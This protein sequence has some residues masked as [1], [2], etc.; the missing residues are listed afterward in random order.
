MPQRI[1]VIAL[2]ALVLLLAGC[3]PLTPARPPNAPVPP[4]AYF[5]ANPPTP[6]PTNTPRPSPTP[7]ATP[8]PVALDGP[9][10]LYITVGVPA[11][12][13]D[14]ILTALA[15]VETVEAVNGPQPLRLNED[16]AGATTLL[17]VT[18]LKDAQAPLL[19]RVYAVVAPFETV[20][21]EAD[22]TEIQFRWRGLSDAPLLVADEIPPLLTALLGEAKVTVVDRTALVEALE[23]TPDALALVPFDE[24]DP[25]M[26]VLSING[27]NVLDNRFDAAGYP[28]A[29]ALTTQG[30]G[31]ALLAQL[32]QP[33]VQQ[34]DPAY[35]NRDP[36][37]LSS[38]IMTGVTAMSRGTAARMER[39]GYTYPAAVISDTLAAA[40][41]TH[42]SNE[43][44]FLDDCQVN[45]TVDNL[46][47]CSHDDYWAALEAVG[48]D[49]VGLSGNH[50]NDFGR[51]GA[52]RS[53]TFYR[54]NE[55]P[56]YGS[57]FNVEEACQPLYWEHNGNRFA[58][59]A[60]LAFG[61]STAWATDEEPGACHFYDHKDDIL[62]LV[63]E[64][65]GDVDVVSVELQYLETYNPFPTP[66]QVLEFRELRAAGADIVTGVQSHVPQSLE[67]YGQTDDGGPGM[68]AYG[69]GNLFFDQMWSWETRTELM[70]RHAIYDGRLL[71][72]EIL[73]AVLENYAQPRWTD[74]DE[75]AEILTR[76]FRAAPARAE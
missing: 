76:I 60:A 48:T 29:L 39:E 34:V 68:I 65:A 73:T 23:S 2:G 55:I 45:N 10:D 64:L 1:A 72:T 54:E 18:Q 61:P 53:L 36:D 43:V 74:T 71:N 42:I 41:I 62:A 14:P 8:T 6:T 67:P 58:F 20:T 9:V 40:D 11:A 17:A 26:K 56:I 15:D 30:R 25:R 49:I 59:V 28:L 52:R 7:P 75:R 57:G 37:R 32:L 22:W 4:A 13:A 51:D 27:Q 3:T 66:Q 46:I 70:A 47:L 44:P 33:A 19:E 12:Y 5:S 31:G 24:I 21:D 50:V 35:T 63:E 16:P 69:L 38:L